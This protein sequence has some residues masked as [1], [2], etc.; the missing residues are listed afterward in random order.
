[1]VGLVLLFVVGWL[2]GLLGFVVIAVALV[3]WT[4]F[5]GDREVAAAVGGRDADPVRDARLCNLIEGLAVGAGVRQPRLLVVD[6]PGVNALAAGSRPD[7]AVLA[8]T[9][10]LLESLDRI[11]MEAVLAEQLF[12][13]RHNETVPGTALVATFGLGSGLGVAADRDTAADLGAVSLT[14]YP[15]GL[16]A[17][18]EKAGSKGSAV[19]GQGPRTAHLWMIDPRDPPV[20][21]RGRI[22]LTDRIEALTEL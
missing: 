7:R 12:L 17:A 3:W 9:S 11:E 2:A 4:R 1:M 20:A 14:R 19:T 10:G 13:I 18:L 6:S 22:P 5:A 8:V 15:P 21:A 16:A